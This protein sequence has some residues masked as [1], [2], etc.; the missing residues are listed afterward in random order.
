MPLLQANGNEALSLIQVHAR[1]NEGRIKSAFATGR[2]IQL[3]AEF[4]ANI[5][6]SIQIDLAYFIT[7]AT[8]ILVYKCYSAQQTRQRLTLNDSGEVRCLIRA[9]RLAPGDYSVGLMVKSKGE[10]LCRLDRVLTLHVQPADVYGTGKLPRAP[11]GIC[12][13]DVEWSYAA[14]LTQ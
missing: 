12:L 9:P 8:G 3:C 6:S 13:P 14:R 2:D 11:T 10:V 1:D 5:K 4:S 7:N